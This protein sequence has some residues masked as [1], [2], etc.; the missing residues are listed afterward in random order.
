V[1]QTRLESDELRLRAQLAR[2]LARAITSQSLNQNQAADVLGVH[3]STVS[4]LVHG[5][6]SGYSTDRLIRYL[7]QLGCDVQVTV[8][9]FPNAGGRGRLEIVAPVEA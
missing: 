2:S 4:N 3:H 5:R 1:N 9:S 6:V 7:R 8:R